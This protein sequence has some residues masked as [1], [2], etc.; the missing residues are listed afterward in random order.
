MKDMILVGGKQVRWA[1]HSPRPRGLP[2]NIQLWTD[3][4]L[5]LRTL[6]R[7][8]EDHPTGLVSRCS[9]RPGWCL[10]PSTTTWKASSPTGHWA[11]YFQLGHGSILPPQS[12]ITI[13][14]LSLVSVLSEKPK[15]SNCL[16][17]AYLCLR[18]KL[19]N[20]WSN[21]KLSRNQQGRIQNVCPPVNDYQA[22]NE[23]GNTTYW[24][25]GGKETSTI[26]LEYCS[27][28][29]NDL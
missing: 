4:L 15:G 10:F 27:I 28:S 17:A 7:P 21:A 9:H 26:I 12:G 8:G 3:Q 23:S 11:G 19:K 5:G 20:I 13:T 6:P 1:L 18:T 22:C 29:L 25:V 14:E 16:Q 2:S 24:K